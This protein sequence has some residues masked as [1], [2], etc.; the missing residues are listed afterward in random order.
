[1]IRPERA[2]ISGERGLLSALEAAFAAA[3]IPIARAELRAV[4]QAGAAQ[5]MPLLRAIAD[6]AT[7]RAPNAEVAAK[8]PTL[9]LSIDQG[10]ELFLAEAHEE[11]PPFLALL[12]DLLTDDAPAIIA[13]FA[14]RSDKYEE[15]QVAKELNGL[16]Q[17]TFSL[18]PMPKGSYA[19]VIKGPARRLEDT[20]RELEIED[21]LVQALLADIEAGG[22]KDALPL[23]AFTLERLYG[24]YH[25]GGSLKLVHYD[26][27][28]RVK[29]SIEAAVERALKAADADPAIRR[30]R[31][32]RLALL[33]RGLIPWLA[34]IDPDTGA[35]R[36]RVARLAEIPAEA[37]PLI[38]LLVE[39]RLLATDVNKETGEATIEP[40]HEALLRQWGT[41]DG[42]LTEDAG[43]LAVLEGIKRAS[44]DWVANN[45]NRA[46]LAHQ[47]DRLAAA[48]RLSARPDLAANLDRTDRDYIAACG[49]AET[50]AKRRRQLLQGA[51]YVSLVA[52][53]IGLV[54]WINQS[55][56]GEQWRWYS[57]DRPF[58]AENI[59]PYVLNAD[60]EH[61]LKPNPIKSFR[62]CAP[63]KAGKDY[64][65]DMVVV[66]AGSFLM[67]S[68]PNEQ[69]YYD[70]EGP[71]H[72]VTIAQAFAVS[73]FEVTFDEWDTCVEH[74]RCR[75]NS[76]ALW[77]HGQRPVIY[78]NWD[79]AKL[80]VQWLSKMTGKPYRLLTEAEYEY[81]T[82]AGSTTRYP[83]G[84]DVGNNNANCNGCGS[85]W[86]NRTSA[87]VGSFTENEFVGSF[88]PNAFGLHDMVGNVWQWVEDCWSSNY[89]GAPANG[90]AW[91]KGNCK[92][93]V[94]RGGSY[95]DNPRDI[96]SANRGFPRAVDE[97]SYMGFRVARTLAAGA[98][99]ITVAPGVR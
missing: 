7:P 25:S 17:H 71:Q 94:I 22:A 10:E 77:G 28:G 89:E 31:A 72:P 44:R 46:W 11:A 36:R 85:K 50:E 93:R 81:A 69:G 16:R 47:T 23:L 87:P 61:A 83:W 64:C 68:P 15:L 41:L 99:A 54:G 56:I 24:E 80:Y 62:E 51:V 5:L 6:K 97:S 27:L 58:V 67:G 73:K 70:N 86:D 12:R 98:G 45:R 74:G 39:Q 48:E 66:P 49:K 26:A 13:V 75:T 9:I 96:R 65:P 76:D 3:K 57:T 29:G 52:I 79:D 34:G 14:I 82:R 84:N 19:E 21:T 33:R 32:A 4:I 92:L 30:D 8:R 91:M 60:A 2:A 20:P 78:V 59:W 42:W 43:L 55:Y 63:R 53:I 88:A 38:Q 90:E 35:P 1:V 95:R 40:A 37:R 18:P